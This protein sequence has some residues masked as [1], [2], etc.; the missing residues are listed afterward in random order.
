MTTTKNAAD[1]SSFAST[2]VPRHLA[3]GLLGFGSF[4]GAFLLMP[5][6]GP[7]SL[8]LLPAG[9]VAL[10]G[11]PTCWTIGLMQ[12][13]SRGRLERHCVDGRCEL[14]VASRDTGAEAVDAARVEETEPLL[15][16]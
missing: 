8:A 11:C 5:A 3:R 13:V 14:H 6:V 1:F 4:A 2:S 7:V 10:R 12:T 15:V 16:P 9:M